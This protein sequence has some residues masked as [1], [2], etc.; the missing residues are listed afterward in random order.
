MFMSRK[1]VYDG[2][3]KWLPTIGKKKIA[4]IN[5][6]P[7]DTLALMKKAIGRR[8][9]TSFRLTRRIFFQSS[10]IHEIKG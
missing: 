9:R 10:E 1:G 4:L 5:T 3:K 6:R 8:Q 7:S 2:D